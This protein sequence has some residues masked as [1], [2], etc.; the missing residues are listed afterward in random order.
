MRNGLRLLFL[1]I[2]S[3]SC[4]EDHQLVETKEGLGVAPAAL[5]FGAVFVGRHEVRRVEVRNLGSREPV[6]V[7]VEGV[8]DGY[9]VTPASFTVSPTR[10]TSVEVAFRPTQT[11]AFGPFVDWLT[12]AK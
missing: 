1:L 6:R 2:A 4:A 8:P 12:R 10:S 3:A 7:S 5:S 11:G 9:T